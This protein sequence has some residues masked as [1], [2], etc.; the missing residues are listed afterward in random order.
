MPR[1]S[2]TVS[3]QAETHLKRLLKTGLHGKS[4]AEVAKRLIDKQ[5]QEQTKGERRT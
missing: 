5:L 1:I 3:R 2:V 4:V